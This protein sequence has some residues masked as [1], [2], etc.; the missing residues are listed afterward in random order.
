MA[1][2]TESSAYKALQS[3]LAELEARKWKVRQE[4]RMLFDQLVD[5]EAFLDEAIV[6]NRGDSKPR[7]P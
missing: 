5:Q 4:E 7:R 3:F 6:N 2:N 1:N